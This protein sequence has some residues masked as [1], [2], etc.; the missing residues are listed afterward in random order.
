MTNQGKPIRIL[1]VDDDIVDRES[2]KRALKRSGLTVESCEASTGAAALQV[3]EEQD[4]DCLLLDYRLPDLNGADL[5]DRIQRLKCEAAPP[6]I[7]LTGQGSEDLALKVIEA[8]AL[9]YIPKEEVSPSVLRRAVRYALGRQ[10]YL[11]HL[12]RLALHDDLTGLGNRA[13]FQS[14]MDQTIAHAERAGSSAAL[15]LIDLDNFKDINDTLGHESGDQLLK[16]VASRLTTVTRADETLARLGGDEFVIAATGLVDDQAAA[17]LAARL[18]AVLSEP[19]DIDGRQCLVAASIGISVCP[20]DGDRSERLL[21]NADLALYMAKGQGG[22]TY[23]FYSNDMSERA[24]ARRELQTDLRAAVKECQFDLHYQPKIE[25]ASGRLVGMEALLRWNRPQHGM[26]S[27]AEFIPVAEACGLMQPL[28]AWVLRR[29]C[30][31]SHAWQGLGR[32]HVRMA[33]NLSPRQLVDDTI[34]DTVEE[35]LAEFDL[36]P[37]DL[38]LEFTESAVM[39][40]LNGAALQLRRLG[41]LGVTIAIDDF[42]IGYSSLA[43]LQELPVQKLKIDRSLV[44]GLDDD[45]GK[46]AIVEAIVALGRK[47]GLAIV[48]EGVETEAELRFV[49]ELGCDEVQGFHLCRPLPADQIAER[50]G[51]T[52]SWPVGTGDGPWLSSPSA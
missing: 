20:R 43:R 21:G 23:R 32:A 38:E 47:L 33:V 51:L 42:G 13:L 40:N 34:V 28:G 30:E 24:H 31:Q 22:G 5:L 29:A 49:R 37:A 3:C 35:L 25:P 39:S 48:A 45:H 46:A 8:G 19:F 50:Y 10:H 6:A 41:A 18:I 11:Q 16:L 15:F 9:D 27:P 17:A 7:F 1:V 44:S 2:V 36:D 26:V 14:Q 4:F 12:N 52:P